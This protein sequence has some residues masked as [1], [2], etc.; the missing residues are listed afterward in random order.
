MIGINTNLGSLIV[1]SNLKKSTNAL[2][3]AIERMTTGFKINHA[4][5]NAA[6]YS[7]STN[8]STKISAYEVAE[9]N[10]LIGLDILNTASSSIE[11]ISSGLSRL[12][13]LAEQAAN[14]TYGSESLDAINKEANSIVDEINRLYTTTEFNGVQLLKQDRLPSANFIKEVKTVDTSGMTKLSEVD[15]NTTIS[16]GSYSIS[17]A[18]ELAKLSEMTNSGKIQGGNFYLADNIDL[19]GYQTGEGWTPIGTS[20]NPFKGAFDGNGY[21]I[22]N[23]Y[24]NTNAATSGVGLFGVGDVLKNIGV[25]NA[26]VYAPNATYVGIITGTIRRN[27]EN[28]SNSYSTGMVQGK[29]NVGGI[30]GSSQVIY[31]HSKA[32][33]V[34]N[35]NVGGVTGAGTVRNCFFTG[36]VTGNNN[37][38]GLT[39]AADLVQNSYTTGKI[40]GN[41][42]VGG[43]VGGVNGYGCDNCYVLGRSE[44]LDGVFVGNFEANYTGLTNCYYSSYYEGLDMAGKFSASKPYANDTYVYDGDVPFEPIPE[45]HPVRFDL[46]VGIDS[47]SSSSITVDT[48]FDIWNLEKLRNIGYVDSSVML[49]TVDELLSRVNERQTSLGAYQNR[50]NS[51]LE[52]IS[53]KYDNLLSSRSTIRD[54][55]IAE[56]SS[57][58]IRQQILQQ[59][60][61]TLLATANQTPAIALQLL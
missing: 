12:R 8:M 2:N 27:T 9:D 45:Y 46:Q 24:I 60:A 23:L 6:N 37:V 49:K 42:N 36:N 18:E 50:L 19:S 28:V 30:T 31:S 52:E 3:T 61:A 44:N 51:V 57:E 53:I 22:S 16:S 25:E 43:I 5:D 47:S 7:I 1:Q 58:Y 40:S 26:Y 54:A 35:N 59:A 34:G 14:G 32:N 33:I 20:A 4:K 55:D 11:L 48:S 38:G 13:A 29:N 17:T 15:L 10:A 39:G 21:V 41:S 56:V